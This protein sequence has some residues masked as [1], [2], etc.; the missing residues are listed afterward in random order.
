MLTDSGN[1]DVFVVKYDATGTVQWAEKGG[2]NSGD[3]GYGIATDAVG[4]VY[5][6]GRFRGTAD[7]GGTMLTSSGDDD[8]FVV[9]YDAVGMVIWAEKGGGTIGDQ[10]RGIATDATGN[11]YATGYFRGTADFG[12]TQ[13]TSSGG[14]DVFMLQYNPYTGGNT[15]PVTNLTAS[16]ENDPEVGTNTL[17]YLPKWDGS[18]LVQSASVFENGGGN[19]GIG[20]T[21]PATG[22]LVIN[23]AAGGIGI[24]LSSAD[25]YAEMRVIRNSLNAGDNNLY[26]GFGAGAGAKTYLYSGP[27]SAV[28]T[29]ADGNVGIGTTSPIAKLDIQAASRPNLFCYE[30]GDIFNG[31]AKR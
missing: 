20:T 29:V 6:T 18:A 9:K 31:W 21:D 16:Q 30:N 12:G 2:G 7:F 24:D 5:A 22:K 11:V 28:L 25:S 26:L 10:G 19:V 3:W 23:T 13:L 8:V 4:N 15:V 17:N 14:D 1:G 27:G